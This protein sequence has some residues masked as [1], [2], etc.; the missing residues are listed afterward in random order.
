MAGWVCVTVFHRLAA[1]HVSG[2]TGYESIDYSAI[3]WLG[4]VPTGHA[5]SE[6]TRIGI[7]TGASGCC[8]RCATSSGDLL[9]RK[10]LG[11][12]A[13]K[14]TLQ[15]ATWSVTRVPQN[16]DAHP[17]RL[18]CLTRDSSYARLPC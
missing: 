13:S 14:H 8:G 18:A 9:V 3:Q 1:N 15:L 2:S 12:R 6:S 5:L 4:L 17:G 10:T 7:V 11:Q 16:S